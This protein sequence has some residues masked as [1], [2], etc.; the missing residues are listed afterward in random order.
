MPRSVLAPNPRKNQQHGQ[1]TARETNHLLH[2]DT[3]RLRTG[4][5]LSECCPGEG[6]TLVLGLGPVGMVKA[7]L[8]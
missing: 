2:V 4:S 5:P 7:K 3:L 1:R 8:L 6:E